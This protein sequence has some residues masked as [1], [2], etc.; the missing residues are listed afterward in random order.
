MLKL[1]SKFSN[2]HIWYII[3]IKAE[4]TFS[5]LYFQAIL[6]LIPRFYFYPF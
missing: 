6:T 2:N 5:S 4:I 3:N 1:Y